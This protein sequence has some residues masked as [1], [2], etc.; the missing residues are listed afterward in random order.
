LFKRYCSKS[1][2]DRD[3]LYI[4]ARSVYAEEQGVFVWD[5]REKVGEQ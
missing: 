4:M 2:T 3:L 5:C 1:K